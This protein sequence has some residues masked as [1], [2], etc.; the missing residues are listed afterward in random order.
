M[1]WDASDLLQCAKL[2]AEL[3]KENKTRPRTV[4]F[5]QGPNDTLVCANGELKRY[6]VPPV[7]AEEIIDTN[8][9]GDAFAG[10]VLAG[11]EC[12]PDLILQIQHLST[13]IPTVLLKEC[14]WKSALRLDTTAPAKSSAAA[15]LHSHQS[16]ISNGANKAL[17]K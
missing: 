7:P 13:L 6:P 8:G 15:A 3:P 2:L 17:Q 11:Y 1:G 16:P 12:L 4:I 14:P 9:A 5:T 10:G